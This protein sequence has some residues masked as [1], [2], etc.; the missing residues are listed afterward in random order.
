MPTL[1][2]SL[3]LVAVGA[4]L[5]FALQVRTEGIDLTVVGVILM[6]VGTLGAVLSMLFWTSFAPYARRDGRVGRDISQL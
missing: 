2:I 3:I 6:I 4:I 1:G 5:A